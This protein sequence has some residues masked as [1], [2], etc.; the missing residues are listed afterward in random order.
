L[1]ETS[2]PSRRR[3]S[4]H[5]FPR[6]SVC[7]WARPGSVLGSR[8]PLHA[9]VSKTATLASLCREVGKRCTLSLSSQW[10]VARRFS[11]GISIPCWLR[12]RHVR[13]K[14]HLGQ[15][16]HAMPCRRWPRRWTCAFLAQTSFDRAKPHQGSHSWSRSRLGDPHPGL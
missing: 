12:C 4:K 10:T 16:S 5:T 11:V 9:S 6:G 2:Q 8:A 7:L 15:V 3:S 13:P 1:V 14:G